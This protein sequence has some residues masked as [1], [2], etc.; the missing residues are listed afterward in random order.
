MLDHS[1]NSKVLDTEGLGYI[2][3]GYY[4]DF[5]RYLR[6]NRRLIKVIT[7]DDLDWGDD[8]NYEN[9][10]AKEWAIWNR[11]LKEGEL[12]PNKIY[13]LI[14]HD[15]DRVPDRTL[16]VL[17]EEERFSIPSNVLLFNRRIDRHHYQETGELLYTDYDIDFDEYKRLKKKRFVFGYHSNALDQALFD[18]D[19]AQEIFTADVAA[20]NEKL[21][22]G[23]RFFSP[24]GGLRSPEGL[25]NNSLQMPHVLQNSVRWVANKR[26]VRF[27][28]SY[29][30]GGINSLSRDPAKRDLRDFVSSW[31]P[32]NRYRVLTHPQY[33]TTPCGE[34]PRLSGTEWYEGVLEAYRSGRGLSVWR[35]V[36]IERNRNNF[37]G[38][39]QRRK[40]I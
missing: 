11:K 20:L 7:Y 5:L 39:I 29:S 30:D 21:G 18:V 37:L 15:V 3:F 24:H 16:A 35:K 1:G 2:P 34:S 27:N 9:S 17:H 12:N 14:Q 10:Y 22:G 19:Q 6:K 40:K 13:V 38:F 23:V 8:Y 28:A 33:Y 4:S 36:E 32:G 25:T 26:T 31:K